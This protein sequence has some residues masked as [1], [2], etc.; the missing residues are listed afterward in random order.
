MKHVHTFCG[1]NAE[2]F[3]VLKQVMCISTIVLQRVSNLILKFLV[4]TFTERSFIIKTLFYYSK[5]M[6]TIIK[7]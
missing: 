4:Y 6:H 1:Q 5:L 2:F 3:L 7:S